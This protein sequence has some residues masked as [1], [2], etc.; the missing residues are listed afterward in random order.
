MRVHQRNHYYENALDR[1]SRS[2]HSWLS[3]WT[4]WEHFAGVIDRAVHQ[5]RRYRHPI[6]DNP[7]LDHRDCV[8]RGARRAYDH[9]LYF[10]RVWG[11]T[12]WTFFPVPLK[13]PSEY[14]HYRH[15]D[16]FF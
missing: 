5:L 4:A 12:Q 3:D 13:L 2:K 14:V 11:H 6:L 10:L 7:V 1:N 15:R 9:K 16:R 8:V